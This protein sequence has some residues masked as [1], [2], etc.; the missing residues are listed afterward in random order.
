MQRDQ[1][2]ACERHGCSSQKPART[3]VLDYAA[4]FPSGAGLER[5]SSELPGPRRHQG[6]RAAGFTGPGE[7]ENT[8]KRKTK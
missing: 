1:S 4:S 6:S 3:A 7:P 8:D 2:S 5:P